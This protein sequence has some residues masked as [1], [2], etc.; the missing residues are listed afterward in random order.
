MTNQTLPGRGTDRLI[1]WPVLPY[2]PALPT[3]GSLGRRAAWLALRACDST[4]D[5]PT[6][7]HWGA[8]VG[9]GVSQLRG[10]YSRI[11]LRPHDAR[12]FMRMLRALAR[13][14]GRH[15]QCHIELNTGDYR[16]DAALFTRAGL[17]GTHASVS[18]GPSQFVGGQSFVPTEHLFVREVEALLRLMQ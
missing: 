12:D 10:V 13:T 16:T 9:V 5:L 17:A 11:G 14:A 2:T 8:F 18:V 6:L 4:D 3:P 1:A 7:G 15:N